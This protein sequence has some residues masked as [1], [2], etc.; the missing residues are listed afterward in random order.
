MPL[1]PELPAPSAFVSFAFILPRFQVLL[2]A[3]YRVAGLG[4]IWQ[5]YHKAL[6][7]NLGFIPSFSFY[8]IIISYL[9]SHLSDY[10][11]SGESLQTTNIY[12]PSALTIDQEFFLQH[13]PSTSG[14]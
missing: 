13:K 3:L 7:W 6:Q 5:R 1:P 12:R 11:P 4:T 10:P 8:L 14:V 9:H 2:G